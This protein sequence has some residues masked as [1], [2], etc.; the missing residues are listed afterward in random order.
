MYINI[1]QC[2]PVINYMYHIWQGRDGKN[3]AKPEAPTTSFFTRRADFP[4]FISL[5]YITLHYISYIT[6]QFS[7]FHYITSDLITFHYE[8]L[9]T[10]THLSKHSKLYQTIFKSSLL[11][12]LT[13]NLQ[14][15]ALWTGNELKS[16]DS[17]DLFYF[18]TISKVQDRL[19]TRWP[20]SGDKQAN[21]LS[22]CYNKM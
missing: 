12:C 21:I 19:D 20:V 18:R 16:I 15:W 4:G 9:F 3:T 22:C 6:L 5:H 14:D 7:R 17:T 13:T 10:V 1:K 2:K 11:S 8:G